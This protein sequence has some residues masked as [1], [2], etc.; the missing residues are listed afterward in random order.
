MLAP[1]RAHDPLCGAGAA[2]RGG[3]HNPPGMPA[4]YMSRQIVTAIA[5][6]EQDPG[7][8]PGTLCAYDVDVAGIVVLRDARVCG[9]A[10][11]DPGDL[12]CAWKQIA[13]VANRRPPTRDN[14][15]RLFDAGAAG[16]LVASVQ[17]LGGTN[18]V[19]WRWK[20]APDRTVVRLDPL[21][22][23]RE[24]RV[25][26]GAET[27]FAGERGGNGDSQAASGAASAVRRVVRLPVYAQRARRF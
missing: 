22:V 18:L 23:C 6:Y 7:V 24:T 25:R 19:L 4:L 8:R 17:S 27:E 5:E 12:R 20:D 16:I 21:E 10:G 9:D 3:R 11:I 2:S 1:K 26:G 13:F 15:S 14:A